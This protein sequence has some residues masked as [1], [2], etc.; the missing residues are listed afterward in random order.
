MEDQ[1]NQN[2]KNLRDKTRW[3]GVENALAEG[4]YSGYM[5]GVIETRKIFAQL[6]KEKGIPGL[7]VGKKIKHIRQYLS[8]PEKLEFSQEVYHKIIENLNPVITREET[9]DAIAGYWQAIKDIEETIPQ[10]SS[11]QKISLW[12]KFYLG[13]VF[14]LSRRFFISLAIFILAV[15]F[16]YDTQTGQQLALAVGK[17][18]HILIFK[19]VPWIIGVG[20]GIVGLVFFWSVLKKKRERL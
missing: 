12:S 9:K 10:L 3:A 4:T 15:L 18:T 20:L 5:F 1:K 13:K 19:I 16:F 2:L 6:L 8:L 14:K 11:G 7:T 17:G